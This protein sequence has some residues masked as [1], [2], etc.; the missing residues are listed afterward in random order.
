MH[1]LTS[2]GIVWADTLEGWPPALQEN[3]QPKGCNTCYMQCW[4]MCPSMHSRLDV[5][6]LASALRSDAPDLEAEA[7]AAASP[8]PNLENQRAAQPAAAAANMHRVTGTFADPSHESTFAAQLFRMAY[9]THVLLMALVLTHWTWK[10]L[11]EPGI[12]A[13]W[14]ISGCAFGLGLLCRVLLHR[15]GRH[16]P[17]RSQWKGSWAW[18]V[19]AALNIAADVAHLVV[20]SA[21]ACESVERAKYMAPFVY[22]S[23]VLV[24]GSHGLGFA[25]K[26]ALVAII[27]IDWTASLRSRFATFPSS[28]PGSCAPWE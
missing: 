4:D 7:A 6:L 14:V 9:P 23:L 18:I 17:V 1:Q 13:F 28:T 12:R 8:N 27:L 3:L 24:N 15:T 21:A 2:L 19:L 11:V 22:L 5:E 10:A 20:A 26:F 16:D 25:C